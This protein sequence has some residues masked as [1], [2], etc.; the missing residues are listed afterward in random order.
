MS[1][2]VAYGIRTEVPG[3][4]TGDMDDEQIAALLGNALAQL[5]PAFGPTP[6]ERSRARARLMAAMAAGRS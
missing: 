3:P 4:R 2:A 6:A 5:R 1:T